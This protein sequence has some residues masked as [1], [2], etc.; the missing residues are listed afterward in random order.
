MKTLIASIVSLIV[1]AVIG[2]SIG[3]SHGAPETSNVVQE[4]QQTIENSDRVAANTSMT[5]IGMIDSGA[6]QESIKFLSAPIVRY[7]YTRALHADKD[8]APTAKMRDAIEA[9]ASKNPIVGEQIKN[10]KRN[11]EA[12]EN[13][14]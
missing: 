12:Q 8:D 4:M 9:L 14:M 2:W 10:Q 13:G 5:A 11:F 7:Y 1:G 6:T 3:Q